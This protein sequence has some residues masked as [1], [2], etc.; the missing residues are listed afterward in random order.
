VGINGAQTASNVGLQSAQGVNQRAGAALSYATAA[1]TAGVDTEVAKAQVANIM[2]GTEKTA[3]ETANLKLMP[4]YIQAQT[5]AQE[6]QGKLSL[7]QI[8]E[9]KSRQDQI[10]AS[11]GQ[12][13]AATNQ[14][15]AQTGLIKLQQ[16]SQGLN[17]DQLRLMIPI[18]AEKARNEVKLTGQEYFINK[19]EELFAGTAAGR[20]DPQIQQARGLLDTIRSFIPFTGAAKGGGGY[21]GARGYRAGD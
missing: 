10:A 3:Q 11:I 4:A 7:Q 17:N 13:F 1:K 20:A 21:T 8:N 14:A 9:S 18:L 12:I 15:D 19:P 5:A 6:A 16:A 2:Q